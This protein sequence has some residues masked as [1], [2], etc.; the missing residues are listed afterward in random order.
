MYGMSDRGRGQRPDFRE[1]A[2]NLLSE[3]SGARSSMISRLES[4]IVTYEREAERMRD[5]VER[6][7]AGEDVMDEAA[8]TIDPKRAHDDRMDRIER[9]SEET[10]EAVE[11]VAGLVS[12]IEERIGRSLAESLPALLSTAAISPVEVLQQPDNSKEQAQATEERLPVLGGN[13]FGEPIRVEET[14]RRRANTVFGKSHPRF[15]EASEK[16]RTWVIGSGRPRRPAEIVEYLTGPGDIPE[17]QPDRKS[18]GNRLIAMGFA[19][20]RPRKGKGVFFW[21]IY[22]NGRLPRDY[23][24][25]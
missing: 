12:Q 8:R 11:R 2:R 23:Q 16:A 17:F 7:K 10:F 4:R 20:V 19:R 3:P 24:P 5:F 9:R 6:L 15:E 18:V 21:P 1:K 14:E 13:L 25:A 22:E